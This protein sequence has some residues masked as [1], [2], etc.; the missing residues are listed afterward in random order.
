MNDRLNL[1]VNLHKNK[2]KTKQ[3]QK[4][5]T[6]IREIVQSVVCHRYKDAPPGGNLS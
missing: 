2:T 1:K 6:K 4:Q 5:K 3:K